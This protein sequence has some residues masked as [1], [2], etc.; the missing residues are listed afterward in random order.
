[1]FSN[2]SSYPRG[3]G[4]NI[5]SYLYDKEESPIDVI[6]SFKQDWLNY[7]SVLVSF[8]TGILKR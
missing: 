6:V 7:I 1:M 2:R 5:E 8:A 4:K 3:K